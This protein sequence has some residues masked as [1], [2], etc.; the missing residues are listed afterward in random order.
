MAD[1][2][3]RHG[4]S[5]AN[6]DKLFAGG[7]LDAPLTE[8]GI[9]QAC[10]LAVEVVTHEHDFT[11][12]VTS[13][14]VRAR[15]TGA[16]VAKVLGTDAEIF[17]DERLN[18]YG[19]GVLT[20]RPIDSIANEEVIHAEGVEDPDIFRDRVIEAIISWSEDGVNTLF[21]A[22]MSVIRVIQTKERRMR[23]SEFRT[24]PKLSNG[25]LYEL[26]VRTLL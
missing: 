26:N 6:R 8:L 10:R 22:H 19:L 5:T 14:L 11:R 15:H 13:E 20:G 17:S 9:Q 12:I 25:A 18:E 1:Y 21:V 4:E 7:A 2:I 3:A 16:E 24:I 23:A